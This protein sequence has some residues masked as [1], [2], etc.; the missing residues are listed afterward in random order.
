MLKTYVLTFTSSDLRTIAQIEDIIQF[1]RK[2]FP[3]FWN[4]MPYVFCVK[5]EISAQELATIFDR[6]ASNF[7]IAEIKPSNVNGR[8]PKAAWEWFYSSPTNYLSP[9]VSESNDPPPSSSSG[10]K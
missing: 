2:T 7:F 8:L 9:F 3:S 1:D 5:S 6:V 10:T 4:Y